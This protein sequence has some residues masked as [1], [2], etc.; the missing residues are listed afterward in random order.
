MVFAVVVAGEGDG[1]EGIF[2][3]MDFVMAWTLH[4]WSGVDQSDSLVG[5]LTRERCRLR[6]GSRLWR[7][8]AGLPET[9]AGKSSLLLC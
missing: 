2:G 7:V 4:S 1:W 6:R 8:C 5:E 3:V 9:R